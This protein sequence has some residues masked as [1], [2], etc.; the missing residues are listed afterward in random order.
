MNQSDIIKQAIDFNHT[1]F[2]SAYD[3]T[4]M[5]Q[6]QFEKVATSVLDQASWMPEE[7]RKAID[8]YV[9]AYKSGRD[10]FKKYV[11]DSFKKAEEILVK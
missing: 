1:S 9:T 6:D 8:N 11:D 7:G 3:A 2:D 10:Q 4:V 5:F